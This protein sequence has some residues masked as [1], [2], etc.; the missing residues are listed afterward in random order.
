VSYSTKEG[1]YKVDMSHLNAVL[2]DDTP[3]LSMEMIDRQRKKKQ[4]RSQIPPPPRSMHPGLTHF[5][6]QP[7]PGE[8]P[9]FTSSIV[10]I[11]GALGEY[12]P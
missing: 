3:R 11:D 1:K 7:P 2:P 9:R 4:S 8:Q 12:P 5:V 10:T 6:N